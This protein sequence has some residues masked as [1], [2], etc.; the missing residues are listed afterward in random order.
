MFSIKNRKKFIIQLIINVNIQPLLAQ[1]GRALGCRY[2]R[3]LRQTA[4]ENTSADTERPP[5]R[6]R[7]RGPF[8]V[9]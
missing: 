7:Q 3:V 8:S 6:V 1:T 2:N 5:D 9:N 4:Y